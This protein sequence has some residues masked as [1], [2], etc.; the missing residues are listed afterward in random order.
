MTPAPDYDRQQTLTA[1]LAFGLRWHA[2]HFLRSKQPLYF[3]QLLLGLIGKVAARAQYLADQVRMPSRRVS[4]S[5]GSI[6]GIAA[7]AASSSIS[8]M[9]NCSR[10]SALK[11]ASD[12]SPC[13][14]RSRRAISKPRSSTAAEP[15]RHR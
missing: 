15:F 8:S 4:A 10:T 13:A 6:D 3:I 5:A 9:L 14:S 2:F 11:S 7:S 12:M 1:N